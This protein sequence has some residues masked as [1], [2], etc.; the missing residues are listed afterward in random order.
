MP[1]SSTS[2][3]I[4]PPVPRPRRRA[5]IAALALALL[6]LCR[7]LPGEARESDLRQA[8]EVSAERSEFDQRAGTQVLIGDVEI[9]QGTMRI[10]ADRVAIRLVDSRLA[11]IEGSGSPIRFEQENDAGEKM[12]GEARAIDYDANGG[13][14][15]LS[16]AATLRRPGQRLT[17][18]RIVFDVRSQKVSAEGG[19]AERGGRVSIRIEPPA[20]GAR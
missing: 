15:V 8:I 4:V 16:G 10:S 18:E 6:A 7:A 13:T 3:G 5:G 11:R 2:S 12:V 9:S 1:L 17:S 19:T 14:L 20:D